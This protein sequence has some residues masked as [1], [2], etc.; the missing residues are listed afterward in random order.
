[1]H[2]LIEYICKEL[3]ELERKID[4]EGKLSM[5]ET[6]YGDMLAHFKKNLLSSEKMMDD[7]GEYSMDGG[8]YRSGNSYARGGRLMRG[9]NG[10]N[11]R[12]TSEGSYARG[13]GRNTRRD[14][15]GRYASEGSYDS[16]DMIEELR[17]LM[18]D[19][20]NEQMRSEF[21]RFIKKIES[22]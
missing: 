7:E 6:E 14:S 22:M 19:S 5:T 10:N 12:Y 11:Y 18:E 20:D 21:Q 4:K 15:M 2:K 17:E 8:P 13:R 3:D 1:M 16:G 9:G